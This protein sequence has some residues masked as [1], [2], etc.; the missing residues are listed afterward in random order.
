MK[1]LSQIFN[2]LDAK[3]KKIMKPFVEEE[4]SSEIISAKQWTTKQKLNSKGK[5]FGLIFGLGGGVC[6]GV[7]FLISMLMLLL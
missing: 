6:G 2:L 3:P 1:L 4:V 5:T 7:A